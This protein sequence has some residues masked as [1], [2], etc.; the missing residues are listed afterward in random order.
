[1]LAARASW[2]ILICAIGVRAFGFHRTKRR[3]ESLGPARP[4]AAAECVL[5]LRRARGYGMFRGNCVSQSLALLWLL[6]RAGHD[7]II[8]IG[9]KPDSGSILAHAWVELNG[10]TIDPAAIAPGY[11]ALR[12]S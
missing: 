10:E 5:A 6:R 8:R 7:G 12:P 4:R 11:A 2:L 1:M 9:V 3:I